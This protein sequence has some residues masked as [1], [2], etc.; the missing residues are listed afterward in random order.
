M[1]TK[2]S[3]CLLLLLVVLALASTTY[4]QVCPTLNST[5]EATKKYV[6]KNCG[7]WSKPLSLVY[8]ALVSWRDLK[9]SLN[10]RK[11]AKLE[12]LTGNVLKEA[13]NSIGTSSAAKN[14]LQPNT[15]SVSAGASKV[16]S[17]ECTATI[18]TLQ[19]TFRNVQQ[20][21]CAAQYGKLAT[22]LSS[23]AK[24]NLAQPPPN[25]MM[26][27]VKKSIDFTTNLS[28][29][30]EVSIAPSLSQTI[31]S[32]FLE[33]QNQFVSHN[34]NATS[35]ATVVKG[36][37]VSDLEGVIAIS[38][39]CSVPLDAPTIFKHLFVDSCHRHDVC[40]SCGAHAHFKITRERCDDL[41]H[42]NMIAACQSGYCRKY[43]DV[44]DRGWCFIEAS[45]YYAA[46]SA[47][48]SNRFDKRRSPLC[49]KSC[50]NAFAKYQTNTPLDEFCS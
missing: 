46:V 39:G 1:I 50:T 3:S 14:V 38:N 32:A 10:D 15:A 22:Y 16:P 41:F 11:R 42:Q 49:D 30:S 31:Q 2:A 19:T 21:S 13:V 6:D 27:A 5:I 36:C 18:K 47:G 7:D 26:D 35:W 12:Q 24:V 4:A 43:M 23:F 45:A 33:T 29:A 44:V 25:V 37:S 17:A 34:R 48:G 9:P 28:K 20:K 8:S 40:Y